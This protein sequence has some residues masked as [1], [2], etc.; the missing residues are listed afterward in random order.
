[1]LE[2]VLTDPRLKESSDVI[3]IGSLQGLWRKAR[4]YE[5]RLVWV[6]LQQEPRK[7]YP[8]SQKGRPLILGALTQVEGPKPFGH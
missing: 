6:A 4:P 3:K 7:A 8:P 5:F 1:V 2:E